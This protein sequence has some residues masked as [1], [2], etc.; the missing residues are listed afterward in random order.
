MPLHCR[1]ITGRLDAALQAVPLGALPA[2]YLLG[3]NIFPIRMAQSMA[4]VH[5]LNLA[6][7]CTCYQMGFIERTQIDLEFQSI[8]A[9]KLVM[10]P[11]LDGGQSER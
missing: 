2:L 10:V 1:V 4:F 6:P 7:I 3:Q 11:K 5:D 8:G 9:M